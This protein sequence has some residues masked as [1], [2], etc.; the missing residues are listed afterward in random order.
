MNNEI[1][2]KS[3][4]SAVARKSSQRRASPKRALPKGKV[5][6]KRKSMSKSSK[7]ARVS[8]Q[9][10]VTSQRKSVSKSPVSSRSKIRAIKLHD[11]Q[12]E[13]AH[14]SIDILLKNRFFVSTA[15]TGS[16]KTIIALY[17]AKHFNF[18]IVVICPVIIIQKWIDEAAMY[19][20]K[21]KHIISYE[22]LRGTK[23]RQPKHGLLQRFDSYSP[24]GIRHTSFKPTEKWIEE[25]NKG[26]F[27]ICDEAHNVRNTSAQYRA[28]T[29]LLSPIIDFDTQSRFALMTRTFFDSVKQ[30]INIMRLIGYIKSAKL[31]IKSKQRGLQLLG[32]QELIDVCYNM[33]AETTEE[34]TSDSRMYSDIESLAYRL[35]TEVVKPNTFDSMPDIKYNGQENDVKNGWYNI[36]EPFRSD[37]I[38]HIHAFE[39]ALHINSA[40]IKIDKDEELKATK[41]IFEI[42]NSLLHKIEYAKIYDFCRIATQT[43][44]N[45]AGSKVVLSL[46]YTDCI[47][48]AYK[49]LTEAGFNC[50]ILNG[51]VKG[52]D[53]PA[54]LDKF[55][56]HSQTYRVIIM[57]TQIAVGIDL[58][59]KYGDEPRF[60][61]IS[62]NYKMMNIIQ[63]LGRIYR[64]GIKSTA[65]S[66]L[67][68]G[69]GASESP[70]I[71][72]LLRKS[73]IWQSTLEGDF[74]YNAALPQNY[75][76]EYEGE[77]EK[78]VIKY[79]AAKR[80]R[81][82]VRVKA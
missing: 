46:N 21:I 43:L 51:D 55:Q 82:I 30:C 24:T 67:F 53:R 52:S 78:R 45:V 7:T 20:V 31:A 19:G 79:T 16:G 23:D 35:C 4:K 42:I 44:N 28:C 14:R 80:L 10:I 25:V 47:T 75:A 15:P 18:D 38:K 64:D 72:A 1:R 39:V 12:V 34:I 56:A 29:A 26:I 65:T 6:P 22:S 11:H 73:K 74:R 8:V 63:A 9:S 32:A 76:N 58:H 5:S 60:M 40:E 37:L 2:S 50:L 81:P 61:Y 54:V 17:I 57:N 62:P 71:A 48:Q 77:E 41:G 33:D 36:T 27:V 49:Y 68:Y 70:I 3:L 59:D 66:R 13:N 69:I